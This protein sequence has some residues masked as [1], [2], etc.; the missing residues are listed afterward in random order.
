L[1]DFAQ[2]FHAA[3]DRRHLKRA[4]N[5]MLPENFAEIIAIFQEQ[6]SLTQSEDVL[7]GLLDAGCL[8]L[9][10]VKVEGNGM[11]CDVAEVRRLRSRSWR[12]NSK[13]MSRTGAYAI[14][15][16]IKLARQSLVLPKRR[17]QPF[18]AE[19]EEGR[20]RKIAQ[21]IRSGPDWR[22]DTCATSD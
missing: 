6:N 14:I 19:R 21:A 4:R 11:Q 1:Q 7:R 10:C 17:D 16:R 13:Q 2:T 9:G 18:H 20:I 22:L 8:R 5:Q 12:H 15:I 3:R